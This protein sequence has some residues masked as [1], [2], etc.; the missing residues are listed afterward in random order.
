MQDCGYGLLIIHL[1]RT[2]VDN[3]LPAGRASPPDARLRTAPTSAR[4][5]DQNETPPSASRRLLLRRGCEDAVQEA[6][7]G[8]LRVRRVALPALDLRGQ[9][10]NPR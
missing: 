4:S 7:D 6:R 9:L 8:G 2:R 10:G 5:T 3:A 1:P